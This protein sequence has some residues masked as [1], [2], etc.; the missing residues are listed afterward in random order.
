MSTNLDQASYY[1]VRVT[2]LRGD[3]PIGFDLYVFVNN[4]YILYVRKGDHF[5]GGRLDKLREKK[6]ELM[7]IVSSEEPLYNDYVARN[8]DIAYSE[9]SS[10]S[11]ES[12]ASIAQGHQQWV[13][14]IVLENLADEGAYQQARIGAEQFVKFMGADPRAAKTILGLKN[15]EQ[16]LSAHGVAVA[17]LAI[18]MAKRLGI[19][20]T[21]LLKPLTLGALLH[22]AGH[23]KTG[24][25]YNLSLAAMPPEVRSKYKRHPQEAADRLRLMKH[26]DPVVVR[27]IAEHEEQLDG[28]GFP[29]KLKLK[30][31]HP[32]SMMV[33]V[34][35]AYDRFITFEKKK[36][37]DAVTGIIIGKNGKY[38]P[39]HINALKAVLAANGILST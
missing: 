29:K 8:L 27:I 26:F 36:P 37:S 3:Q 6:L 33:G 18:S 20:D 9:K 34:A 17:T 28:T 16:S 32:L 12:R 2:T 19:T 39:E 5:D 21:Q 25:P 7:Y 15:T 23:Y 10:A 31:I 13:T 4:K 11:I 38:L 1:P 22:D 14:E 24:V 30:D 35:N